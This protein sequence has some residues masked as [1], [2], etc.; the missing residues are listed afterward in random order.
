VAV[1]N[2]IDQALPLTRTPRCV[3][4][5]VLSYRIEGEDCPRRHL[6]FYGGEQMQ[7]HESGTEHCPIQMRR[8]LVFIRW[9]IIVCVATFITSPHL[10]ETF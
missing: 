8:L 10:P 6:D 5:E 2:R 1:D 3:P 9:A 7:G 4:Q